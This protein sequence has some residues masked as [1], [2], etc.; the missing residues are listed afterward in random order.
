MVWFFQKEYFA[1]ALESLHAGLKKSETICMI[2]INHCKAGAIRVHHISESS[3]S[4]VGARSGVSE[5]CL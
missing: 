1:N 2:L 5:M 3:D 4:V